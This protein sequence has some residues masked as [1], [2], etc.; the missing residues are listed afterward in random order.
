MRHR[1]FPA[2]K[3]Q[4]QLPTV[5]GT[6]VT[7]VQVSEVS[8]NLCDDD[9][10]GLVPATAYV[11]RPYAV[12][13]AITYGPVG[14]VS[15]RTL[16]HLVH[17]RLGSSTRSCRWRSGVVDDR[18][19]R[20]DAARLVRD[21]HLFVGHRR[22]TRGAS[23]RSVGPVGWHTEESSSWP[24]FTDNFGFG[25]V[26]QTN[27]NQTRFILYN[28][29]RTGAGGGVFQ[30]GATFQV[31]YGDRWYLVLRR[32]RSINGL[33]LRWFRDGG[34]STFTSTAWRPVRRWCPLGADGGPGICARRRST[35][36]VGEPVDR[37]LG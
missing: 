16:S 30:N 28:G 14:T 25:G 36:S 22:R 8:R 10:A 32:S 2:G 23:S 20:R 4:N 24:V 5:A 7:N 9:P 26:G 1:L 29:R 21:A 3:S 12:S 37:Q 15:P 19:S 18:Q 17:Y 34:V 27:H 33:I 31:L 11:F 6:S 35:V 13:S